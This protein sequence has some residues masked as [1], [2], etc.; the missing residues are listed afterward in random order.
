MG[1]SSVVSS[2]D[3]SLRVTWDALSG[4]PSRREGVLRVHVRNVARLREACAF[5]GVDL[6]LPVGARE[7]GGSSS[8]GAR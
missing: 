5:E 1:F 6:Q 7:E 2:R 3:T 8:F 4:G